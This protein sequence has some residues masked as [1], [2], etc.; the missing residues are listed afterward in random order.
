MMSAFKYRKKY[1]L[2]SSVAMS[3]FMAVA[4]WLMHKDEYAMNAYV[5]TVNERLAMKQSWIAEAEAAETPEKRAK[6][7]AHWSKMTRAAESQ[8]EAIK[9]VGRV[10][11]QDG[12]PVVG[13]T[14]TMEGGSNFLASGSGVFRASTDQ[15]GFFIVEGVKGLFLGIGSVTKDGYDVDVS[16]RGS[17]GKY[18]GPPLLYSY[19][20]S[21]SAL[22]WT[23][24]TYEHPYVIKA[25]RVDRYA[26]VKYENKRR[27]VFI[28]DEALETVDFSGTE[29]VKWKEV[30]PGDLR[31]S[32]KRDVREWSLPG[33]SE[34]SVKIDA[35]NGWVKE[36]NDTYMYLAPD[37]GGS[38]SVVFAGIGKFGTVVNKKF[39]F[40]SGSTRRY[41]AVQMEIYPFHGENKTLINTSY[42]INLEGGR[43]LAVRPQE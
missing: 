29:R 26:K 30:K 5:K 22:V 36:T 12:R 3:V 16:L 11:D 20:E 38:P 17:D 32:A 39:Y 24:Y 34:W 13:A 43:E 7:A 9:F 40:Y 15:D 21:R 35:I 14:V 8:I 31:I 41:G 2:V 27:L 28:A 25:W 18:L 37:Q 4:W 1:F 23:D 6:E 10:I 33:E 19:K 42:V